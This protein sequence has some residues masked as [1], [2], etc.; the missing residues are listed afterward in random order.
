MACD[1]FVR[2][3]HRD[4]LVSVGLPEPGFVSRVV[5]FVKVHGSQNYDLQDLDV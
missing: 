2:Y 1:V 5:S 3:A 4:N